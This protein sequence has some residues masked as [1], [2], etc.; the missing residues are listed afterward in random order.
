ML[1]NI[2]LSITRYENL[3]SACN[4][5][6][7]SRY[8]AKVSANRFYLFLLPFF[9]IFLFFYSFYLFFYGIFWILTWIQEEGFMELVS[10]IQVSIFRWLLFIIALPVQLVAYLIS[11]AFILPAYICLLPFYAIIYVFQM[12]FKALQK[13]LLLNNFT[14]A[15]QLDLMNTFS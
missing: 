9:L 2:N 4:F 5:F 6:I 14:T 15:L 13:Q 7:I 11:C 8:F 10:Y 3:V 12:P 1:I